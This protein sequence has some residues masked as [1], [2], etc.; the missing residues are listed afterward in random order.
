MSVV[1][2]RGF[3]ALRKAHISTNM[4]FRHEHKYLVLIKHRYMLGDKNSSDNCLGGMQE[5]II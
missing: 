2:Y 1:L 5:F 4:F 3:L